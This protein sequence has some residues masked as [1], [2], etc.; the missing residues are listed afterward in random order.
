MVLYCGGSSIADGLV[1]NLVTEK[2]D[3]KT[4][5]TTAECQTVQCTLKTSASITSKCASHS[6]WPKSDG[7]LLVGGGNS[8]VHICN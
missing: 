6:P 5:R 4:F 2:K 8:V 3:T 1:S 7:T